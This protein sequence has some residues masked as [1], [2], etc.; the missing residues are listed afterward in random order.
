MIN[1]K[2]ILPRLI[3][4]PSIIVFHL[5]F[6]IFLN[7]KCIIVF[8]LLKFKKSIKRFPNLM[9][10]IAKHLKLKGIFLFPF[11]QFT[12]MHFC[13]HRGKQSKT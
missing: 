5:K 13:S 9:V 12:Q 7:F 6:V 4:I 1:T 8:Y 11:F 3:N 2:S 10:K